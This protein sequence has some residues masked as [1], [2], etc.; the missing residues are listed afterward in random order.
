MKRIL[1]VTILTPYLTITLGQFRYGFIGGLVNSWNS[2]KTSYYSE[3]N[4]YIIYHYYGY[5]PETS[6]QLNP[7]ATQINST[8]SSKFSGFGGMVF[9]LKI[10]RDLSIQS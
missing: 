1:L 8:L 6:P 5:P 9:D 4:L 10:A 2:L 7:F 3:S